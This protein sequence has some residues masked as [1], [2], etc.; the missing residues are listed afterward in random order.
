MP[1]EHPR[2]VTPAQT[3]LA[4][5]LAPPSPWTPDR[6]LEWL[7]T[8]GL[9][10]FASGTVGG[11][12]TRRYHGLLVAA[13]APPAQRTLLLSR[14]EETL[15]AGDQT[16]PLSTNEFADGTIA[17]EGFRYLA[18]FGLQD[19][20][21]V[22]RY[23]PR[24]PS[25]DLELEKRVWM[26]GPHTTAV[27]YTLRRAPAPARLDLVP[28]CAYRDMH[29]HTTGSES[30]HFDVARTTAGLTVRAFDGATPYHLL[31]DVPP[32]REWA[33]EEPGAWWWRFLH[34][35][36]RARGQDDQEDLYAAGTIRCPLGQGESLVVL[37]TTEPP[38]RVLATLPQ[39]RRTLTPAAHQ[40]PA[41][42]EF[43]AQLRRAAGQ[44]LVARPAPG[45][46]PTFHPDGS[47]AA[48][49]VIAG[50][51]WFGDWGRDTMIALPGLAEATGRWQEAADILRTFAR[52]VD[53]GMLPNRFP[54]SGAPLTE[55]DYNTADATLWYFRAIDAV[56]QRLRGGLVEELLPVLQEIVDWHVRG[57]RFG[58]EVD[59]QDGLLRIGNGQL[60]WMDAQ[61]GDW[62]VTPRD[63]KPVELAALWHHALVLIER[64]G[65]RLGHP[66]LAERCAGLRAR[67]AENFGRRYW[68]DAG[69]YLYDVV[70]GPPGDDH[71]LRPN[72]IIAAA[73]MDCPITPTQRRAV[74]DVVVQQL[75][76][77]R[78]LRTLSPADPRYVG[79]YAGDQRTRDAAYHEGAAWPWLLGP[80]VD[81]HLLVYDDPAA[82]QRLV[83]PMRD[84][85]LAEAGC[86]SISE[87]FDGD[88]PFTP[89]GC[90]AQAWSVAEVF[91]AW[92]A[93]ARLGEAVDLPD[94][95]RRHRVTRRR[96]QDDGTAAQPEARQRETVGE[97]A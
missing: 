48:Q 1:P 51:H 34:R 25:G 78:G 71:S 11:A 85:L 23:M 18:H 54:D 84:H 9:G 5:A 79:R 63:G 93:V 33:F 4:A 14:L 49:T 2:P 32:G 6:A 7:V 42:D 69:G 88:A 66:A 95:A 91:R 75:W 44:F 27:A 87:L 22:W 76:T 43:G 26:P 16:Y 40:A 59:P 65:I 24:G 20:V 35:A 36:E 64:W 13:L 15:A 56:D 96:R 77:P 90:I 10:G 70:D 89:G 3:P 97:R 58:I 82:A 19:G 73:L 38:E 67:A 81:A 39:V 50:Y 30:W 46:A 83:A 53:K 31:V 45:E 57:T 68:Y 62:I 17:P 72:Q 74:V 47:P 86:G 55:A 80:L 29:H 60:T 52:Y 37:V 12:H 61:I 94:D 28:L 92:Q 41:D 8:D 21:P